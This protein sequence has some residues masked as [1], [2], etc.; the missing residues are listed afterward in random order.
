MFG[1]GEMD[2]LPIIAALA[3][4]GYDG[5]VNAERS[6]HSHRRPSRRAAGV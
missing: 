3:E 1:E 2:F 6:R 4:V 5:G